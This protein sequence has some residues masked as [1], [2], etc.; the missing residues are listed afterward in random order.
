LP[1]ALG[2][3]LVHHTA[4]PLTD[5][6][7]PPEGHWALGILLWLERIGQASVLG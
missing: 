6:R 1:N 3:L 4:T 7:L 2:G 5:Q